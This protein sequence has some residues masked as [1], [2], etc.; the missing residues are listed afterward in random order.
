MAMG[1]SRLLQAKQPQFSQT[2]F[3]AE[4]TQALL[5]LGGLSLGSHRSLELLVPL[6]L[7]STV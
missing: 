4:T 3:V 1:E 5:Y 7:S 2:L 6:V